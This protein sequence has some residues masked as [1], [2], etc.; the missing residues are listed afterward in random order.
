MTWYVTQIT[1][2]SEIQS[3]PLDML[4]YDRCHPATG[5]DVDNIHALLDP[6]VR[7]R[8]E[9]RVTLERYHQGRQWRPTGDRWASFGYELT[10]SLHTRPL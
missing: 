10:G 5:E 6:M 2:R 4:R 7:N 9:H 3:F 8:I 1:V